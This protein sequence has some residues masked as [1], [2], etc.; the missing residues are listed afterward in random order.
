MLLNPVLRHARMDT[1]AHRA[2][3]GLCLPL[4]FSLL[5]PFL[6]VFVCA[7]PSLMLSYSHITTT[8]QLANNHKYSEL[9]EFKKVHHLLLEGV[10]SQM[11][12]HMDTQIVYTR[13]AVY[14]ST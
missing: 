11:C 1:H 8:P 5:F 10:I 3:T 7:C 12:R 6:V 4:L 9:Q 2:K 14:E 13:G